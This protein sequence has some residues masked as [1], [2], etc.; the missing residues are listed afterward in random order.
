MS[1]FKMLVALFVGFFSLTA[2]A[3]D[4]FLDV[5]LASKHFGTIV[6]DPH[7]YDCAKYPNQSN[8]GLGL[9]T[10]VSQFD[11]GEGVRFAIDVKVGFYNNTFYKNSVY[12]LVNLRG[13][14]PMKLGSVRPGLVLG[15]VTGYNDTPQ[16]ASTLMPILM[17]NVAVG[18]SKKTEVMFGYLPSR[19]FGGNVDV[20]T[21][22]LQYQ[23][24]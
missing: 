2:F 24:K 4:T 7:V 22:Q 15:L 10:K 6:C 19:M 16:Q 12:G 21:V 23:I 9:S 5:N 13:M 20:L 1:K 8:L 14:D 17:P 3:D 18:L 11:D